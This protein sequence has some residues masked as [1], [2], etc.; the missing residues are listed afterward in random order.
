M[1]PSR[2][3]TILAFILVPAIAY[4]LYAGIFFLSDSLLGD[5][6]ILRQIHET[7]R[8]LWNTFW[9]DYAHALPIFYG[10]VLL[11]FV[12]PTLVLRRYGFQLFLLP[13]VLGLFVGG[14]IGVYLSG[15]TVGWLALLHAFVGSLLGILFSSIVHSQRGH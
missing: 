2:K 6:I 3:N 4:P 1:K 8:L 13:V 12:L 5:R 10:I 11:L 9:A 15:L 14:G 7:R